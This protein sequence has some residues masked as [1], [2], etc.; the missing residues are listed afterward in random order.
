MLSVVRSA[1]EDGEIHSLDN[2]Y[3][4]VIDEGFEDRAETTKHSIRGLI[5]KLN[6]DGEIKRTSI[7]HYK[8]AVNTL[9]K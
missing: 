2:L 4:H 3:K 7:G 5:N 9:L 6:K 8:I 1:F